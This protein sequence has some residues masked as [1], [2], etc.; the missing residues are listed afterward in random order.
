MVQNGVVSERVTNAMDGRTDGLNTLLNESSS[1]SDIGSPIDHLVG[2][3][4]G[5]RHECNGLAAPP[6]QVQS[7]NYYGGSEC[8]RGWYLPLDYTRDWR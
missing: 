2:L 3:S 4:V 5:L 7:E 8:L 6:P 1:H